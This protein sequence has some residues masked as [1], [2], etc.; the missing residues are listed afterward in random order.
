MNTLLARGSAATS[1]S[2]VTTGTGSAYVVPITCDHLIVTI[3]GTG[4][5]SAGALVIEEAATPDYA[6]I[7]SNIEVDEAATI[8]ANQLTDGAEKVIHIFG[9]FRA[10]RTRITTNITGG[11]SITTEI[12]SN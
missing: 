3:R 12:V 9:T 6:G 10:V 4:T 1:L 5:I 7:W 8:L 2:A 11:G